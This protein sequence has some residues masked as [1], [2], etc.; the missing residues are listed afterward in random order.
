MYSVYDIIKCLQQTEM[1][2]KLYTFLTYY[3]VTNH[4]SQLVMLQQIQSMPCDNFSACDNIF[5]IKEEY[6]DGRNWC[7]NFGMK[8]FIIFFPNG[9]LRNFKICLLE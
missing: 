7:I 3:N 6:S 8:Y 9:F 1:T 2:S 4:K 5:L